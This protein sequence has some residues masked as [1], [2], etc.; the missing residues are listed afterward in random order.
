M[1]FQQTIEHSTGATSSYWRVVLVTTN[2]ESSQT[3]ILMYGYKDQTARDQNKIPLDQRS[4]VVSGAEFDTWYGVIELDRR[5][6]NHVTNSY[7]YIKQIPNGE[8][9]NATDLL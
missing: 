9:A 3:N 7:L 4:Y 6:I 8:F 5:S 1:A 2:Y